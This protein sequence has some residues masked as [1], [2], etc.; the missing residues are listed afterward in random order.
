MIKNKLFHWSVISV[1]TVLYFI[2]SLISTIHVVDFFGMSNPLWL[3]ISLA[4][5]FELGAAASLA[6]LTILEKINKPLIWSLFIGLTLFQA[7]GN[8]YYSYANLHDFQNWIELFGLFNEPIIVQKRILAIISGAF[9]P[10]VALGYIKSLVNYVN[11]KKLKPI[12]EQTNNDF[13]DMF[14]KKEKKSNGIDFSDTNELL[15]KASNLVKETSLKEEPEIVPQQLDKTKTFEKVVQP[16]DKSKIKEPLK[17][18]SVKKK[19]AY[20]NTTKKHPKQ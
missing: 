5:G 20:I 18:E 11:P 3:S 10:L 12:T 9:L 6:S 2:V 1:F 15:N 17:K 7:M 19:Q 13:S 16:L 4:I 8:M 14:E